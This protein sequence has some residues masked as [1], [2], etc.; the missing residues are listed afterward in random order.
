MTRKQKQPNL[1]DRQGD[2]VVY[3]V[4]KQATKGL[5]KLT[6]NVLAAGDSTSKKHRVLPAA[7]AVIYDRGNGARLVRVLKPRTRLEHEGAD[8]HCTLSLAVGDH[9]V[10]RLVNYDREHGWQ[11]VVD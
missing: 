4:A 7:N 11:N 2:L 1:P 8:G 10:V 3:H 5:T 9:I 6:T